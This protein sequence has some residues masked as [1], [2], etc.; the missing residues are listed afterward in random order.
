[1]DETDVAIASSLDQI[2]YI[3]KAK[4]QTFENIWTPFITFVKNL[5]IISWGSSEA[6]ASKASFLPSF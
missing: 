6:I 3:L 1:M 4:Q 5:D 2:T